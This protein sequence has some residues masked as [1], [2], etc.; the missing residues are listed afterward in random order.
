M[1]KKPQRH[2]TGKTCVN[3]P[4]SELSHQVLTRELLHKSFKTRLADVYAELAESFDMLKTFDRPVT[5]FGS[6]KF[7]ENNVHYK[8]ARRI[9]ARLAESGRTIITGGGPGIMEA[10]NRGALDVGGRSV[11]FNIELPMEQNLNPYTT[12]NLGFHYFF[13]R[14]V[15]MAFASEAYI[16][17][18]GGYGTLDEFFEILTLVQTKK[19]EPVPIILVGVD[20]WKYVDKMVRHELYEDHNAIEKEDLNLYTITD[21]DDEVFEL[22]TCAPVR[23]N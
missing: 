19:I 12:D 22:V 10:A 21:D 23:K 2:D 9:A 3:L 4:D 18:P 8:Q 20:Y 14:K 16:Y 15:A 13:T 17:F 5:F 7:N 6:S 11:G 1:K